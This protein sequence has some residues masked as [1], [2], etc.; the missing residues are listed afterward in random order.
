MKKK[1]PNLYKK[2]T[3]VIKVFSDHGFFAKFPDNSLHSQLFN[4]KRFLDLALTITGQ[5][6]R[7]KNVPS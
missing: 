4:H 1:S 7:K 2:V 6:E 3:K 5:T